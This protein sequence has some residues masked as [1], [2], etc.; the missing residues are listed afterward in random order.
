MAQALGLRFALNDFERGHHD[1]AQIQP[2]VLRLE[3]P[4]SA[5]QLAAAFAAHRTAWFAED[6]RPCADN[7]AAMLER[8]RALSAQWRG[9]PGTDHPAHWEGLADSER[10]AQP[11]RR[12]A[13]RLAVWHPPLAWLMP[14]VRRRG[15]ELE[16]RLPL[17]S[18]TSALQALAQAALPPGWERHRVTVRLEVE[19]RVYWGAR[20]ASGGG[21]RPCRQRGDGRSRSI[22]LFSLKHGRVPDDSL[23][24]DD[25]APV[26]KRRLGG[27]VGL[28][29]ALPVLTFEREHRWYHRVR[30]WWKAVWQRI[31]WVTQG[32]RDPT[33][34]HRLEFDEPFWNAGTG[35]RPLPAPAWHKAL[36]DGALLR[37]ASAAAVRHQAAHDG[38]R[39]VVMV[40]GGLSCVRSGFG[41]WL[42]A[43][44][45]AAL[46]PAMPL[47]D[48]VCCWRFEHD[49]F[50][51]VRHSTERLV[52]WLRREVIEPAGQP[53]RLVLIAH[54][55]GGNVVRF[56]LP[57]LRRR[58]P[59]WTFSAM[60]AGSPH[61]GTQLFSRLGRRW[62][63]L[64]SLVGMVRAMTEGWLGREQLAQLVILERGLAYEVPPGFHD[65]EPEGVARMSGG[66][67]EQLPEGMWLWGSQWGV[68]EGHLG[69][70]EGMWDWL[71]EDIGGAEVGG[72]GLVARHSALAGR[73]DPASGAHDAS[74]VFHTH[75]FSHA[76]T[77]AQMAER[78]AQLLG[79]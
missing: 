39:H 34:V 38:R 21:W 76:P 67:P 9:L 6:L 37:P 22:E 47:L 16:V 27:G 49:T 19:T 68:G 30:E 25:L 43:E 4:W 32:D 10:K 5:E 1:D 42:A 66:R 55:R 35:A 46:W 29:V 28:V 72:D 41:A 62:T 57:L 8:E 7:I 73:D 71:V 78:L 53:G 40:H 15:R 18:S 36:R 58:F 13:D 54:S 50:L 70:G 63:G 33:F 51:S 65:V 52:Q 2:P 14:V 12:V 56:A 61:L 20:S 77:R 11:Q 17:A 3:G 75:Y 60:T 69:F 23:Q 44:P 59:A 64:A 31:G 79:S 74:P 26:L 24:A 48:A 45:G